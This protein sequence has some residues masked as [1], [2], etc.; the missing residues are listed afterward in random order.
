MFAFLFFTI[1]L[2]RQRTLLSR[3]DV[4]FNINGRIVSPKCTDFTYVHF[5]FIAFLIW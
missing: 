5:N 2:L 1:E 4:F 3:D